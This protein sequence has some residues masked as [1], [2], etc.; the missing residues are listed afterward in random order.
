MIGKFSKNTN[1][2]FLSGIFC[3]AMAFFFAGPSARASTF[4]D[5]IRDLGTVNPVTK[6]LPPGT[7]TVDADFAIP[8]N[9]TL[10]FDEGAVI[11][12]ANGALLVV[13]GTID[14]CNYQIFNDSNTDPLKGVKLNVGSNANVRPEWWGAKADNNPASAGANA[15]AIERAMRSIYS[16]G[17]PAAPFN[18]NATSIAKSGQ[19]VFLSKGVYY[20]S[21]T[22][23]LK[24]GA[25]LVGQGDI[26]NYNDVSV[27]RLVD[28]SNCT[29]LKISGTEVNNTYG[30][31]IYNVYFH[32]GMQA[33]N[34]RGINMEQNR[35]SFLI[36]QNA[37]SSFK[38]YA[39]YLAVNA[40]QE[41]IDGNVISNC[42]RG[43]YA[44]MFDGQIRN[45]NV[46]F[47]GDYGI[48]LA[49]FDSTFQGN[50]VS[51]G[52]TGVN[53]L[54]AGM[55]VWGNAVKNELKSC[56]YG[57]VDL[58]SGTVSNNV[59]SNNRK[60]GIY[61]SRTPQ[62][63]I[64]GNTIINNGGY[65][66]NLLTGINS[67]IERNTLTGNA[68]GPIFTSAKNNWT[69]PQLQLEVSHVE[70]N[71]GVDDPSSI[72]PIL[73]SGIL[74]NDPS[75]S[76]P[77]VTASKHWRTNNASA[78]TI[79]NFAY[80]PRGKEIYVDV[81][82]S[83]TTFKFANGYGPERLTNGSFDTTS[84]WS[85]GLGTGYG[86]SYD[87]AKHAMH[88]SL[89]TGYG[90]PWDALKQTLSTA[91]AKDEYY[92]INFTVSDYQSGILTPH[93]G[94]WGD[95]GGEFTVSGNGTYT[96]AFR[97]ENAS[98][99]NFQFM[100]TYNFVGTI[101]NVSVKKIDTTLRGFGSADKKFN[102]GDTV[103]CLKGADAFWY[104]DD[105][106]LAYN[107]ISSADLNSD[108]KID[109]T[110]LGI[111]KTDFLKLTA[112]LANPKSDINADGQCTVKDAGIM[113][114]G[115]KP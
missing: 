47:T 68:Q 18:L 81:G 41:M 92:E 100:P 70:N 90:D 95:G 37:F 62:A 35:H 4:T 103:R 65:G 83:N 87:S 59:I 75:S 73:G 91:A 71:T 61:S 5:S 111:L 69:T 24:V 1:S 11:N 85:F 48:R 14:D 97:V 20:V 114:S 51:G 96:V 33:E 66:I 15:D 49:G 78:K 39:I 77:R 32:G 55:G 13:S 56:E 84:G 64:I 58:G 43:I 115:W 27:L 12:V 88:H 28:N 80:A 63:S 38:D 72:Y 34:E 3:L 110:D 2:F 36:K 67:L 52:S 42:A 8:W 30:G 21:R 60:D 19:E 108:S 40:G 57:I 98:T 101:D 79:S 106:K 17:D 99:T 26:N 46:S 45:N 74:G 82:D 76:A 104:C 16:A 9:I 94:Y 10:R 86:W 6:E 113:M 22:L 50:K 25:S 23:N 107:E 7:Y 54:S 112:N 31:E 29:L 89:G 44:N 105:A 93:I 109:A 53:C 102:S